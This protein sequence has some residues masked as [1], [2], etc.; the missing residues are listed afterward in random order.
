MV[1]TENWPMWI[2]SLCAK[3]CRSID[4]VGETAW[5]QGIKHWIQETMQKFSVKVLL[6]E[7]VELQAGE[8]TSGRKLSS[9][10]QDQECGWRINGR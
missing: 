10:W 1:M 7:W 8:S 2:S 6:L 3:G 5:T 9:G 4:L